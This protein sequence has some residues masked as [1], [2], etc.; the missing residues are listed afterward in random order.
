VCEELAAFWCIRGTGKVVCETVRMRLRTGCDQG[1][2]ENEE[3]V[4]G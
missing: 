1:L 2:R 4:D 3:V